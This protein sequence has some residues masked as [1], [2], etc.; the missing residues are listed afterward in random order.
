VKKEK[1]FNN[2]FAALKL[3]AKPE[4]AKPGAPRPA[5][6]PKQA[7]PPKPLAEDDERALFLSTVGAVET[8]RGPRRVV[9]KKEPPPLP[10]LPVEEDD[11]LTQLSELVAGEGPFEVSESTEYL[12]GSVAGLDRRIVLKLRRGEYPLEGRL[13]LHG[14]T[15]LEAKAALERFLPRARQESRRC[16]LVIHGRG[17]HAEPREGD[18]RPV[19]RAVLKEGV[20]GWLSQ[21]PLSRFVLAFTSA[22]PQDGGTGAVYVLLRR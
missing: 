19:V 22:K 1:P 18:P 4:P 6:P 10:A 2:P 21:G 8:V 3:A 11:V 5:A 13:D 9:S 16:V 17:L 7:T 12:E 15:R 20:Q 14:L